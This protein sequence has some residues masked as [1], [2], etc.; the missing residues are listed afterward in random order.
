MIV[1]SIRA[2]L[3]AALFFTL[4]AACNDGNRKANPLDSGTGDDGGVDSGDTDTNEECEGVDFPVA[5]HPPLM[6]IVLDRSGSMGVEGTNAWPACVDAITV[7]TAQMDN[8]IQF[9]LLLFPNAVGCEVDDDDPVVPIAPINAGDIEDALAAGYPNGGGTPTA[10]ALHKVYEYLVDIETESRRFV[11]LATDGAP[12]CSSDPTLSCDTCISTA[13]PCLT[14]LA[15]LDDQNTYSKVIE[16]HD[17]WGVDTFVIG[18]GGVWDVWDEVLSTV[19][20]LG[21]TGDDY[22]A[23]TDEGPDQLVTAL[24]EIAATTTECTFDVDWDS[25]DASASKDPAMVN[26]YVDGEIIPFSE[27]CSN[28]SGWH[29]L[30]EDTIELCSQLCYNYRW[31]VVSEVYASF[32]CETILE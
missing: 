16:Y 32:G 10:A 29:W 18:L 31:G 19:A 4:V 15:C 25:L 27:D 6:M 17:F 2:A 12:N 21:G 28:S 24:Q 9:G 5:G 8:Q 20:S 30:D 22:P 1:K 14:P 11:I 23:Q 3:T 26:L 13:Y 7:S